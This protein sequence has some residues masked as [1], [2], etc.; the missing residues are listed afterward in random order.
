MNSPQYPLQVISHPTTFFLTPGMAPIL[1]LWRSCR[2]DG[3]ECSDQDSYL[4]WFDVGLDDV[5]EPKKWWLSQQNYVRKHLQG[6]FYANDYRFLITSISFNCALN[7]H[8][9]NFTLRGT[10]MADAPTAKVYL[11]LFRLQVNV[12]DGQLIV[13]YPPDTEKYYWAFDPAGLD[14]LTHEAAEDIGLPTVK[15]SMEMVGKECD[16][17][18]HDLIRDF[19]AAKGLNP[20]SQDAA[21]AMGYPIMDIEDMK[22]F[23]RRVSFHSS[24]VPPHSLMTGP[25][26]L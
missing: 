9:D 16:E 18:D 23:A 20:Y 15:F 12:V 25:V 17:W 19:H 13:T 21:I 26:R 14:R 8:V 1:C 7:A 10:F 6:A 11:F 24:N 2:L 5:D 22:K 4:L 3:H